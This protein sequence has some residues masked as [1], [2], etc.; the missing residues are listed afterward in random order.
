MLDLHGP[1]LAVPPTPKVPSVSLPNRPVTPTPNSTL[2]PK[3]TGVL[4]PL[5]TQRPT[6]IVFE[7]DPVVEPDSSR[8][9]EPKFMSK[10]PNYNFEISQLQLN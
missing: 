5:P 7:E 9:Y 8:D 1:P 4:L 6:G 3:P 10:S 2:P